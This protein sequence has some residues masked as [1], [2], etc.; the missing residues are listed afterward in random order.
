VVPHTQDNS[1]TLINVLLDAAK[2]EYREEKY[3]AMLSDSAHKHGGPSSSPPPLDDATE[4][5]HTA[6]S[7]ESDADHKVM[8]SSINMDSSIWQLSRT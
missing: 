6:S 4:A 3:R 5:T 2:R 7:T 1:G 8:A